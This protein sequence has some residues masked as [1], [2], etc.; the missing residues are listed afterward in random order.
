M[1]DDLFLEIEKEMGA[2]ISTP[3]ERKVVAIN[4]GE[5]AVADERSGLGLLPLIVESIHRVKNTLRS[6]RNLTRL[7]RGKFS[8]MEFGNYFN[9]IV[10]EDLEKV[11]LALTGLLNYIKVNTPIRKKNTV[12]TLM[13][14]VL[15]TRQ[16]KLEEKGVK[17]FK[18]F[19]QNL[20]ETIVPDEQ[21]R[22]ILDSALRYAIASVLSGGS[23]GISTK[24]VAAR[25]E[26]AEVRSQFDRG[27][28]YV[29]I[30][31]VFA[32]GKKTAGQYETVFRIPTTGK[33]ELLDLELRIVKEVVQKNQGILKIETDEKR[34]RAFILLRL[35]VE[36]R[37]VVNFQAVN[38]D[39]IEGRFS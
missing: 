23:I 1:S 10:T 21:L 11:D 18:K 19:E 33:E 2:S 20:P 28:K 9:R 31:M 25:Q 34:S 7:S 27:R 30:L 32:A 6:T 35:P 8:D 4:S 38:Q 13:E 16:R 5:H 29:Q 22:Y 26:G 3:D 14:A 12:H 17:L 39:R 37:R 36:R 24:S 15:R